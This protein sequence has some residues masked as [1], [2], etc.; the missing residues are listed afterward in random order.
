M[1]SKELV[2]IRFSGMTLRI[3]KDTWE[4]ISLENQQILFRI[5]L[6]IDYFIK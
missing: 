4:K 1:K 5:I 6:N 2:E 3:T